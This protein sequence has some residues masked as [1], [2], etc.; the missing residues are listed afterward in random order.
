MPV[1]VRNK[2]P[3]PTVFNEKSTDTMIEWAGAGDPK[4]NDVQ[5]VPDALLN[6]SA[7]SKCIRSGILEVLSD[8]SAGETDEMLQRSADA[9]RAAREAQEA[10]VLEQLD[11]TST[12]EDFIST[13]CLIS[14]EDIVMRAGDLF[15]RP[16]LADRFADRAGEF[17]A[18]PT[19]NTLS[20]GRPEV[21]WQPR[22]TSAGAAPTS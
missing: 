17:E 19:G 10:A 16:P 18:V 8:A 14:G 21:T 9:A 6:N 20:D 15:D 7:F 13:K 4:G 5:Q 22:Q 1:T 2:Q 11:A 12:D 3:G